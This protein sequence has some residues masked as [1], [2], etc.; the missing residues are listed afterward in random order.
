MDVLIFW[1]LLFQPLKKV[2]QHQDS[3]SHWCNL[4]TWF[5]WWPVCRL[6]LCWSGLL[7]SHARVW[8]VPCG[9]RASRGCSSHPCPASS[10]PA[11]TETLHP[12]RGFHSCPET[13]SGNVR[14]TR[15]PGLAHIKHHGET[16]FTLW[17][18][19]SD[20]TRKQSSPYRRGW[21][22]GRIRMCLE[23]QSCQ[24]GLDRFQQKWRLS[25][26]SD[27][28]CGRPSASQTPLW[29]P[30][31]SRP[32]S[33]EKEG[34]TGFKSRKRPN[35]LEFQSRVLWAVLLDKQMK[36]DSGCLPS[37]PPNRAAL[38]FHHWRL[39]VA[40]AQ[41]NM[42][43]N[44]SALCGWNSPNTVEQGG[45]KSNILQNKELKRYFLL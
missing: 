26:Y 5:P 20:K 39:Y 36:C 14:T 7:S 23:D 24:P 16:G 33:R 19:Q 15:F 34:E 4:P 22:T 10:S 30:W 28:Q 27:W 6:D 37:A 43:H 18:G 12:A 2:G 11:H 31:T 41:C 25:L 21:C 17:D 44:H 1:I 45:G 8:K 40:G 9:W 3:P 35:C 29:A 13:T 32:V 42:F 38:S